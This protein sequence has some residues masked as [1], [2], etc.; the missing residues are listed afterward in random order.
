MR[1]AMYTK[2]LTVSLSSGVHRKIKEIL[3]RGILNTAFTPTNPTNRKEE[4]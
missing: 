1:E 4:Q 2:P 3:V